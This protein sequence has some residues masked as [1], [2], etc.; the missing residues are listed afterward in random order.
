MNHK[1]KVMQ[2]GVGPIGLMTTE[3]LVEKPGLSIVGA[4]DANPEKIG[5][6]L[7]VLAGLSKPLGVEVSGDAFSLLRELDA[8]VVILT[9][10][11]SLET[12]RPQIMEII[13]AGKKVVS[14]C[15]ELTYPWLTKPEIARDIDEA[16]KRNGASV[17]STGVNPGFLMDF[18]PL[19]MSGV[20][21]RVEKI[22]AE[23]IQDAQFRR[24]PFQQ[25]IGAGLNLEQ[26]QQK[27]EAGVLRHVGLVESMH[28]IAS[29]IGWK[30]ERTE[31]EI[32]PVIASEAVVTP[33][34]TVKAGKVTGVRQV[35]CAYAEGR[36][37]I[38]LIFQATVG[39]PNPHD[40]I[41]IEGIP[42]I[43]LT[44]KDGVNGDIATCAI[45]VNAIPAVMRAQPGLRTM[46]DIGLIP[47]LTA[48]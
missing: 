13:S 43:E 24:L 33:D 47:F 48:M 36:E 1:I 34:L 31:D 45:L 9:T 5:K 38:K 19:V 46:V 18:L 32:F 16:A 30:L 42:D 3:C 11:S 37:V 28:L 40:R 7:G 35:S 39:E 29:G 17:L 27:V 21:K 14:S 12:I 6:D 44:I 41:L 20:C 2:Y 10:T 4:I 26:F 25:K 15:E 23:R 22:V 8:D